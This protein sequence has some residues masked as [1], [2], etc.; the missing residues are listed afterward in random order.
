MNTI[1]RG[2]TP[3]ISFK[4]TSDIDL[5]KLTEIWFTIKDE[6]AGIERT[7]KLSDNEVAVDNVEKTLTVTLSQEDTLSFRSR[8]IQ[9]QIRAKDDGNLSYATQIMDVALAD[10][11]KGF[12]GRSRF[13]R[14]A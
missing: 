6:K 5:S 2:T 8:M 4:I 7:F 10:V 3:S 9:I 11:L 12:C 1:V 13:G 14:T